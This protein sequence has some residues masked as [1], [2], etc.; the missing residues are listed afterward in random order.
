VIYDDASESPGPPDAPLARL[1]RA[2]YETAFRKILKRVPVLLI[3]GIDAWNREFGEQELVI[4]E[5]PVVPLPVPVSS[6]TPQAS[7]VYVPPPLPRPPTAP[8]S[9][10]PRISSPGVAPTTPTLEAIRA[11]PPVPRSPL[12]NR[13]REGA[14]SVSDSRPPPPLP[15]NYPRRSVDQGSTSPRYE[16]LTVCSCS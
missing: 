6:T 3:G 7:E 12:P 4:A 14:D 8:L 2:I 15:D 16:L 1:V 10:A 13:T 9:H 11:L 5:P